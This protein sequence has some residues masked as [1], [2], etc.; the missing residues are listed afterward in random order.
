MS[1]KMKPD[2]HNIEHT[3]SKYNE[4]KLIPQEEIIPTPW[5][6]YMPFKVLGIHKLEE[7]KGSEDGQE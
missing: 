7:L 1:N 2:I 5:P 4:Q 6:E 3:P